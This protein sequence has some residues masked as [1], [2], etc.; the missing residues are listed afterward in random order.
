MS[1]P[2]V[3]DIARDAL[4]GDAVGHTAPYDGLSCVLGPA[5]TDKVRQAAAQVVGA[6]CVVTETVPTM[7]GEDFSYYLNERPGCFFFVGSNEPGTAILS[8]H[9]PS[10][11][12]HEPALAIGTSVWV[13]LARRLLKQC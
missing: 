3:S 12:L 8:H 1:W 4:S 2:A 5:C 9:Q 11:D 6:E 7:A 10:F 13:V